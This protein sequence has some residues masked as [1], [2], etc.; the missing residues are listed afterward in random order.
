MAGALDRLNLEMRREG[1]AALVALS[2]ENVAY[3]IGY[4]VPSHPHN[5]ARRTITVLTAD[6]RSAL[7]VVS[8]EAELAR[9]QSR[10]KDVRSY[11]QF[12]EKPID[13]LA[14]VLREFKVAAGPIGMEMD[15]L[16]ALD[17]LRLREH[18]PT[19]EL[20]PSR[21]LYLRARL[22]KSSDEIAS[23]RRIA[24][25]SDRAEAVAWREVR[26]GMTEK[27]LA[28]IITNTVLEEG[29]DGL[30]L[31]VGAGERS[32]IVNP[33][34]TDRGLGM[35]DVIR[36]EVLANLNNYQSNVTRTG[37]LGQSTTEQRRIWAVLMEARS[38]ALERL[39][40][41]AV[42]RDL[43]T[44]YAAHMRKHGLEPSI[45]FLG[46]GIGLS[47]HEE[48]YI[49]SDKDLVLEPGIVLT[50]EPFYMMPG[51]MGFHIEDMFLVT[52]Q[53]YENLTTVTTNETLIEVAAR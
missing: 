20:R 16:P 15:F 22:V 45:S 26:A 43:W 25:I 11:N 49:T 4:M 39:R 36:V 6:G 23:L 30:R 51:R 10:V 27:Q 28:A 12:T 18:F 46:H 7:I 44:I 35:D 33:K 34:P 8:V 29:G 31:L 42:V 13:V 50:Y 14:D 38:L 48:P 24:E 3:A 52:E 37:V 47:G 21:E 17:Y 9:Q 41:G 40:P 1:L 5:R 32:G 53:G 2:P 19:L